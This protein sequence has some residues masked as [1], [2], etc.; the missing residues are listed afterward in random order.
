MNRGLDR[1]LL[2]VVILLSAFG[3][4]IIYS[5][6][7]TDLNLTP[8]G[9]WLHQPRWLWVL[10]L[11]WTVIATGAAALAYRTSFR[12]LEWA[13][14]WL[15]GIALVILSITLVIGTGAGS[16]ASS[17]SWL[18]IGSIRIGQPVELA[19]L[20]TI[21]MLA[22]WFAARREAPNTLR[23]LIPPMIITAVPALLVLK[24]PDLGS[25][26]VFV[27]IF[28]A[29][30]Y[31]AG[32]A[33]SLLLLLSSPAISLLLAWNTALWSG[34]MIIL[35]GLL[36][37]W[38][39]FVL[40]GIAVYLANSAMGV[41]AFVVWN[42]L[43]VYQQDR[44]RSFLNPEAYRHDAAF[45]A[46]QSKVAIGSGGWIGAGLTLGTQKRSGFISEPSTD[47]VFAVVGEE[48]GLLGV[49]LALALFVALL[50]ILVR[51][52]RR[53]S[54]PFASLVVFGIVG[55]IFTHIF[56]N[57]GMTV[58]IMPITGIPLPFFSYGGSFL[59]ALFLALGLAFRAAKEARAAGYVE[60]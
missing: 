40:E 47:F 6:G 29:M 52:A 53:A 9:S 37:V 43:D 38:R 31:W 44:I 60:S 18:A 36:L 50:I 34:W 8:H 58:S 55:V 21:L 54:D 27:G 5:A 2:V 49:L 17:K 41:L 3:M 25:A 1:S 33:P 56:E 14:P 46:I 15:Y 22:R 16:A 11:I 23:G 39:P 59:L 28:F 30:L 26:I 7:Q 13:T 48:L 42:R 10:Q 24:Q 20:A 19:K 12:I 35:F 4:L 51:I 57:V 32:V 45:Q